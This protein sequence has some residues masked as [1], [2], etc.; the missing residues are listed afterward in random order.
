MCCQVAIGSLSGMLTFA[1][2][3]MGRGHQMLEPNYY[4]EAQDS[5][6]ELE[7]D[8]DESPSRDSVNHNEWE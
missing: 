6:L 8:G 5:D 1:S 4:E 3:N 2:I 7:W